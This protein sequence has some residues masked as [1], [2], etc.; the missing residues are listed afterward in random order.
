M[1]T[2]LRLVLLLTAL[3]VLSMI[4]TVSGANEPVIIDDYDI[5]S[6]VCG[7]PLK[8]VYKDHFKMGVGLYGSSIQTDSLNSG[9]ISE[10]IKYHFN[11]VTYT[12]LMKP[13]YLL[14]HEASIR[15]Y[16]AGN[17]EPAVKFDSVIKGLD[18]CR[19][20]QIQMRGHVLVWHAQTP[21]WFFREGYMSNEEYVGRET[22]LF[23]LESYIKQVLEFVQEEYPGVVY[24]WDVVNEAVE[25]GAGRYETE[26]GFNIRT[27]HGDNEDNLWYKIVG[28]D[29]VEKSFEY[30]RRYA[31]PEVKLFY[32]DYNTFQP[33]RREAIYRLASHLKDKG[34]IDGI[35]MQ[36]YIGLDY[37]GLDSGTDNY[38]AAL[39]R[40]GELGLEIHITELSIDAGGSS[41]ILFEKQAARYG[42][43]FRI[44]TEVDDRIANI[45]SVTVFGLMDNYILY[46]ND[47]QTNRLFDGNLKPKP[48]FYQV[49]QPN[50]PW[51]VTKALYDGAL[52]FVGADDYVMLSLLPGEYT[53]AELERSA[54]DMGAI[55]QIWLAKGYILEV[56][57]TSNNV[58]NSLQIYIGDDNKFEFPKS[59]IGER[60]VIRENTS[61]NIALN[62]SVQASHRPDRAARAVDGELFTSWSPSDKPP[63]WLSVD[64][65]E[66][67][68]L[69]RWVVHHRGGGG[70]SPDLID[71]PVNTADFRLQVSK[72]QITWED[73]DVVENNIL[74][75][76]DRTITPTR[77]RYVRL[78]ITKPSSF[79]F[80][81]EAVIYEL[82]VY[83]LEIE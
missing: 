59:G 82:E 32:N 33:A 77:A 6:S 31:V 1:N 20:N 58:D 5:T 79:D 26:S 71:G 74:S 42:D 41:D 3:L 12:N 76:T 28:V 55:K 54:L 10:I 73:V 16:Q 48:A 36:S 24:A 52:K 35:G 13:W 50:K 62:T 40:F 72:D 39:T 45:T 18:F 44:L 4:Y 29:Y 21:D 66:P 27:K 34:L 49:A 83:G 78:L 60:I 57:S 22:M 56:F 67:Y 65:G 80:D 25:N 46:D 9:A 61:E 14:D 37:P 51:Y 23:R 53:F 17:P 38:K 2:R 68:I 81:K 64:L 8:D 11:S 7:I 15:N 63:Y 75:I 69:T 70:F 47:T 43:V 30:A 19:D